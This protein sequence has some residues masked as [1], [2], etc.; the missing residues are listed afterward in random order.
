[1]AHHVQKL[2]GVIAD[3]NCALKFKKMKSGEEITLNGVKALAR[4]AA[5]ALVDVVETAKSVK[6]LVPT[7]RDL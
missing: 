1:M 7:K 2:A 3:G 4:T 6:A 5:E